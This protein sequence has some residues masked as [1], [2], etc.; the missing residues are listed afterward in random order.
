MLDPGELK[1]R[2]R[3]EE[4]RSEQDGQDLKDEYVTRASVWAKLEPVKSLTY[5]FGQQNLETGVTHR[6]TVRRQKGVTRPEDLTGQTTIVCDGQRYKVLHAVDLGGAGRF[7]QIE[8][9]LEENVDV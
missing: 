9:Q 8:L 5:W 2:I 7:T 1:K 4:W 3:I 6:A